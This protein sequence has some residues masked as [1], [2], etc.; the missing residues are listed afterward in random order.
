MKKPKKSWVVRKFVQIKD[1]FEIGFGAFAIIWATWVTQSLVELRQTNAVM[2]DRLE[3]TQ[4][5][6]LETTPR[7]LEAE[8]CSLNQDLVAHKDYLSQAPLCN[9]CSRQ[10]RVGQW[11]SC[12]AD[13]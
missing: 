9:G 1:E 8:I 3:R 7:L 2:L 10:C 11:P 5:R 4:A 6:S 13:C 12:L